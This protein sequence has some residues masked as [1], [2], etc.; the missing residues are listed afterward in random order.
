MA[1]DPTPRV[2]LLSIGR[3]LLCGWT[4]DSDGPFLA[5]K[6][7]EIGCKIDRLLVVDDEEKAIVESVRDA[8]RRKPHYLFTTGGLGPTFDDMTL[9]CVAKALRKPLRLHREAL[10]QVKAYYREMQA[11]GVVQS[12]ALVPARRKMAI[13][14]AGGEPLPNPCG[15]APG[16][17]LRSGRTQIFCLPGVPPEMK[18]IFRGSILPQLKRELRTEAG[19]MHIPFRT[20]DESTLVPAVAKVM[21]RFPSVYI[22]T[23]VSGA[24][25]SIRIIATLHGPTRDLA[26]AA[27]MLKKSPQG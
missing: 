4:R 1:C 18:G 5:K 13:L 24:K 20:K 8:L 15:G 2:I 25:A 14:P 11:K 27:A 12:A 10:R 7:T 17:V 9:R 6:L 3:E 16:V 19:E 26:P 22:K 23:R 21:R